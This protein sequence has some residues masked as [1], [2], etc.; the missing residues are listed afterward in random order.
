MTHADFLSL[1][2]LTTEQIHALLGRARAL[3]AHRGPLAALGGRSVAMVFQKP[4]LRTRSSFDIAI[5]ELGGHPIYLGPEEIGL[6]RRES[7]PDVARV[8]SQYVHAIVARTYRH[9][10]LLCL[11]EMASVPVINALSDYCHPCQGLADLLT[12][13]ECLGQLTGVR[14]AYIGDGNN[15]AH[16]LLHAAARVGL[17]LTIATPAGYTP[18]PDVVAYASAEA[19]RMGGSVTLTTDPFEAARDADALYTDV[20]TSMGQE[21]ETEQRRRDFAGYCVDE[22]LVRLAKPNVI[23]MH[24]LPAHR[25]EEIADAVIDGPHSV[26]FQQAGNR[27]HTQKA[28]L[29]WLLELPDRSV[30]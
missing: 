20:W 17:Q 27:L 18:N 28:V 29:L 30:F 25:G 19:A 7:T 1:S 12:I 22:T 5:H 24:D 4:S 21:A 6:G 3:K 11:A 10:D 13:Q 2:D 14:L 15:V 16:T 26:V 8:L 9:E 23:V